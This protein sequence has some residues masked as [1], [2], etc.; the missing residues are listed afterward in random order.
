MNDRTPILC[1]AHLPQVP[2]AEQLLRQER[3]DTLG[4]LTEH[5]RSLEAAVEALDQDLAQAR[6]Q[7]RPGGF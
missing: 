5:F 4:R 6:K 1:T 2:V 7:V 3:V